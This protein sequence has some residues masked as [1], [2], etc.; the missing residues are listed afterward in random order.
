MS[1]FKPNKKSTLEIEKEKIDKEIDRAIFVER[2]KKLLKFLIVLSILIIVGSIGFYIFYYSTYSAPQ[3]YIDS[4]CRKG[5]SCES[6][7]C[8]EKPKEQPPSD[9]AIEVLKIAFFPGVSGKYDFYARIKNPDSRWGLKNF[10]YSFKAFDSDGNEVGSMQDQ[11]YVLPAEEKDLINVA[12]PSKGNVSKIEFELV[13]RE[14]IKTQSFKKPD[15]EVKNVVYTADT[16]VGKSKLVGRLV[17][18]SSYN[19][20]EVDIS[21]VL[22][23]SAGNIVGVNYTN[24]NALQDKEERDFT[25]IWYADTSGDVANESISAYVNVFLKENFLME[26]NWKYEDF[27]LYGGPEEA[28]NSTK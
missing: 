7:N 10:D 8:V 16:D 27:Q 24:L 15:I 21:A 1:L 9:L 12:V 20:E 19:F 11:S 14:W 4:D 3:C 13:P 26:Y 28:T 18:S 2:H 25:L 23:D 17:N 5:Y 22:H 6:G